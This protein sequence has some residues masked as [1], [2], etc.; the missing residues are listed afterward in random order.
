MYL[1]NI[2]NKKDNDHV[3][4][5]CD[6]CGIEYQGI[7]STAKKH[8]MLR[9]IHSCRRCVSSRAGK[10]TAKKMSKIYSELYSGDGNPA[11][12]KDVR[13]KIS[14]ALKG[15]KLS[16]AHKQALRKPKSKTEKIKEAANRP[17]EVARRR[18]RMIGDK[19]PSKRKE[20]REKISNSI[21]EVMSSG[22]FHRSLDKGWISNK[23]TL[24][25]IWCRS[26]LEKEFL[27]KCENIDVI[28]FIE[29]AEAIKI[30]YIHEESTHNYLPDFIVVLL[31][32][33]KIIVETK[34]SYFRAMKKS[35]LK[36]NAL[37]K[38]CTKYIIKYKILQEGEI[39]K[40]TEQLQEMY[41][42]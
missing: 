35:I 21:S 20:V 27:E 11:K 5:K 33:N 41:E 24:S 32:G 29:S 14:K 8:I 16:E 15:K 6:E 13:E 4:L 30:P 26:G 12:R 34:S 40:W 18:A 9:N 1:C 31:N 17:K 36:E 28:D 22:C 25:P 38:Y 23:K 42:K 2:F 37:K 7:F 3:L 10:K 19:N 39:N